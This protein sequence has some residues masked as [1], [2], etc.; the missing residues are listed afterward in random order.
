MIPRINAARVPAQAEAFL[1]Q[2]ITFTTLHKTQLIC[3]QNPAEKLELSPNWSY[4]KKSRENTEV[5]K[6]RDWRSCAKET[7]RKLWVDNRSEKTEQSQEPR[8]NR[9]T[10]CNVPTVIY[11]SREKYSLGQSAL[12]FAA[13]FGKMITSKLLKASWVWF[14]KGDDVLSWASSFSPSRYLDQ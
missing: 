8:E 6:C 7:L 13:E 5:R 1:M 12:V 10:N 9:G 14:P 11:I 4:L 3:A 2:V